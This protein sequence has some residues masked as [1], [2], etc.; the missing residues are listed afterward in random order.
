M[1]AGEF[2]EWLEVRFSIQE[3]TDCLAAAVVNSVSA[4]TSIR[5]IV[6]IPDSNLLKVMCQSFDS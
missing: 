6:Q 1:E 5:L 4:A 2:I 3:I